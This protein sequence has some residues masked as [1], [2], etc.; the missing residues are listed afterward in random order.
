MAYILLKIWFQLLL[1]YTNFVLQNLGRTIS[2]S[3]FLS[4]IPM[5][6][7]KKWNQVATSVVLPRSYLLPGPV[8]CSSL[9]DTY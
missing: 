5:G 4:L 1:L 8:I 6:K 7:L 2:S 3:L 9:G